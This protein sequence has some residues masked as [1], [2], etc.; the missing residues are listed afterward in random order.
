MGNSSARG[1]RASVA[2]ERYTNAAH[3]RTSSVMRLR[4]PR[5]IITVLM[6]GLIC[7]AAS[8]S[9]LPAELTQLVENDKLPLDAPLQSETGVIRCSHRLVGEIAKGDAERIKTAIK[10]VPF[11]GDI[12]LCLN[13][14]GGDFSEAVKIAEILIS[15]RMRTALEPNA[16]CLSGCAFIFMAGSRGRSDIR[17]PDRYMHV[18]ATLG[19]HAPYIDPRLLPDVGFTPEDVAEAHK[20]ARL[21]TQVLID[22]FVRTEYS[23]YEF[24]RDLWIKPSLLRS[25]LTKDSSEFF[26]ID[27]IGKAGNYGI[28]IV[29]FKEPPKPVEYYQ[30]HLCRNAYSWKVDV[31]HDNNV[32]IYRL[33]PERIQREIDEDSAVAAWLKL[34]HALRGPTAQAKIFEV[35]DR[36]SGGTKCAIEVNEQGEPLQCG[37]WLIAITGDAYRAIC[38]VRWHQYYIETKLRADGSPSTPKQSAKPKR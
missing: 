13:S 32:D 10:S 24:D 2:L 16:V 29:G 3:S 25:A 33:P 5:S 8:F 31:F 4:Y 36:G 26:Y 12:T 14:E 23:R 15:S 9:A 19:F 37:V 28:N 22:L 27:T 17:K 11:L 6:A 7:S 21:A 30:E 18:T 20:S 35:I 38:P 34:F 1:E